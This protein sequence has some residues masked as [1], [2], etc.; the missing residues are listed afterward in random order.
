MGKTLAVTS[1]TY[2]ASSRYLKY[3]TKMALGIYSILYH[4]LFMTTY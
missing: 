3:F 1:W 4:N 2:S